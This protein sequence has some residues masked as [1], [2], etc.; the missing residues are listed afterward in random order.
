M[1]VNFTEEEK[2]LIFE[3][4]EEV[5]TLLRSMSNPHRLAILNMLMRCG[6]MHVGEILK[7]TTLSQSAL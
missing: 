2:K 7:N 3:L 5:S 6:E 4:S 1:T